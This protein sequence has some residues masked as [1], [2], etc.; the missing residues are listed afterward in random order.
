MDRTKWLPVL[1]LIMMSA[2]APSVQAAV[3]KWVDEQG[4]VHYGE[5]P[6]GAQAEELKIKPQSEAQ[7]KPID[8]AHRLERQKRLLQSYENKRQAE[9]KQ[10]QKSAEVEAENQRKCTEA[11]DQLKGYEEARYLYNLDGKGER[12]I[13]TDAE[14]AKETAELRDAIRKYCK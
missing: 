13:L 7:T 14:R 12:K 5:R 3:Y 1:L 8:P 10:R 2:L 9:K 6:R 4:K 11:R